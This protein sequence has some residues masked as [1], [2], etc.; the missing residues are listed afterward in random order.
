MDFFGQVESVLDFPAWS[1]ANESDR[2]LCTADASGGGLKDGDVGKELESF[3]LCNDVAGEQE[4]RVDIVE[5]IDRF[6]HLSDNIEDA[7]GDLLFESDGYD[8]MCFPGADAGQ[9]CA[10]CASV[11]AADDAGGE[12]VLVV[13]GVGALYNDVAGL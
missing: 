7:S 10:G 1:A 11:G 6:L 12:F 3:E 8:Q 9:N 5:A 4:H 13:K 2:A